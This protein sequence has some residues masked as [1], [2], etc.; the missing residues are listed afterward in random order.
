MK[1][2]VIAIVKIISIFFEVDDKAQIDLL[3][4]DRKL[5]SGGVGCDSSRTDEDIKF[6]CKK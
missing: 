4:S 1:I 6:I 5:H 2:V 3:S